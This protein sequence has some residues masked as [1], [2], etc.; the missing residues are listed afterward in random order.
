MR[1]IL[2]ATGVNPEVQKF[3]PDQI[4]ALLPLI[5]RPFIQH[6][7]EILASQGAKEFEVILSEHPERFEELLGDGTRWGVSITFHLVRDPEHPWSALKAV[8]PPEDPAAWVVVADAETLPMVDFRRQPEG[9]QL[10]CA[11]SSWSGWGWLAWSQLAAMPANIAP[12][13]VEA[14]LVASGAV[15]QAVSECLSVK[16]YEELLRSSQMFFSGRFPG[17]LCS[18]VEVEPGIWLS[19][20]V[21]I[22]PGV[23]IRAPVYVGDDSSIGSG[24]VLGPGAVIGH[25]CVLDNGSSVQESIVLPG[26]YIGGG[27]EISDSLVERNRLVNVRVGAVVQVSEDFIL[28]NLAHRPIG[29]WWQSLLARF[30][31]GLLL[32]LAWPL[33]LIVWIG[34]CLA[35]RSV[36]W[37]KRSIACLPEPAETYRLVQVSLWEIGELP[38]TRLYL[39]DFL[40]RVVPGLVRVLL[41]GVHLTGI[42]PVTTEE[43]AAMLPARRNLCRKAK[44]GLISE[45]L[46]LSGAAPTPDER[47]AAESFYV[48][49]AGFETDI[50]LLA[51]YA[52]RVVSGRTLQPLHS[53]HRRHADWDREVNS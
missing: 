5:D 8:R 24:V 26:S 39:I 20:N 22:R 35:G 30:I 32:L 13:A 36:A 52:W 6:V 31:A 29:F 7:V 41:G 21:Q 11:G 19:R 28:G 34:M 38:P 51:T 18:G 50:G 12:V 3:V 47:Y 27:L 43:L 53:Q 40:L 46:I 4:P 44:A 14:S 33:T 17:L 10:F 42:D 9:A 48:A 2:L 16:T 37:R 25:N 15:H 45:S 1:V 49:I 23:Q